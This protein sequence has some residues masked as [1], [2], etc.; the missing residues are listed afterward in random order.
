MFE[1]KTEAVRDNSS[2]WLNARRVNDILVLDKVTLAVGKH[3]R[4]WAYA[5]GD[6]VAELYN[7]RT[8]VQTWVSAS[9][10][11]LHIL[12]QQLRALWGWNACSYIVIENGVRSKTLSLKLESRGITSYLA[13]DVTN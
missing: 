4:K 12:Q 5:E 11:V 13:N 7:V 9:Q 6:H 2:I 10:I 1:C 3:V 8:C